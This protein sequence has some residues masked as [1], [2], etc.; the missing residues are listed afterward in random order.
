MLGGKAITDRI[1]GIGMQNDCGGILVCEV[2]FTLDFGDCVDRRI[3][4]GLSFSPGPDESWINII[5]DCDP[6][7]LKPYRWQIGAW[8]CRLLP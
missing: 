5:S 3:E 6:M 8:S 1:V 7:S 4:K 2:E